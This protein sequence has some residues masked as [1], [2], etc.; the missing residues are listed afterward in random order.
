MW[1]KGPRENQ[2]TT[3]QKSQLTF[4][5]DMLKKGDVIEDADDEVRTSESQ[6]SVTATLFT[7]ESS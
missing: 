1:L 4:S 6:D 2:N 3:L 7:E 5:Q